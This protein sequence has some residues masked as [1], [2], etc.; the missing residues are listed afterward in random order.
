MV[1]QRGD[2]SAGTAVPEQRGADPDANG[3]SDAPGARV[4]RLD[5]TAVAL[6]ASAEMP[7]TV[8]DALCPEIG[9]RLLA[10]QLQYSRWVLRRVE[11]VEFERDRSVS[12]T[13]TVEF[14]IRPDAP[15]FAAADEEF[16]LVPLSIMQR[17]TLVNLD[18]RDENGLA[19]GVPGLRVNQ[20]LDQSVLLAA[21]AAAAPESVLPDAP[22][23][24]LIQT[25]VTGRKDAVDQAF[26]D[27]AVPTPGDGLD[28]LRY[29][30]LFTEVLYRMRHDFTLYVFL[31]VKRRQRMLR[32]SFEEP[33][34]WRYDRARLRKNRDAPLG[35]RGRA[36]ADE[37]A[38][39]P[40]T[41][42]VHRYEPG[43]RARY[44]YGVGSAFGIIPTKI[45]F[46]VPSAERAASY[47]FEVRAPQGLRIVRASLVAGRPNNPRK[48]VSADHW[49]GHSP[50]VG[51]HATEIPYGSLCRAQVE[52]RLPSG[53]WLATLVASCWLITAVL[54][55]VAF[56]WTGRAVAQDWTPDQATNVCVLLISTSA[57]V[58]AAIA[59]REFG[60][61]AA[62]LLTLMRLLGLVAIL[63]PVVVAAFLAYSSNGDPTPTQLLRQEQATWTTLVIAVLI[64]LWVTVVW[65]LS[66]W[67]E[68]AARIADRPRDDGRGAFARLRR[69]IADRIQ[70]S[71]WN[72]TRLSRPGTAVQRAIDENFEAALRAYGY[73]TPAIGI[74]SAEGSNEWYATTDDSHRADVEAIDP[75]SGGGV[76]VRCGDVE[77]ACVH[78][79]ACPAV[80][81][82]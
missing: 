5:P 78:S 58:A 43:L 54:G 80:A 28:A 30:G 10:A 32:M 72:M 48:H 46:Q 65:A 1:R 68:W 14:L 76:R 44:R 53:G 24:K 21:A 51:L 47:H 6:Q 22:G 8:P 82:A 15:R 34:P 45:R 73:R 20:Q 55:S 3:R 70:D 16:W 71:P 31:P 2:D 57:G 62:R 59:Q 42:N 36:T 37:Q 23:R 69:W 63:M 17:R 7:G 66:L 9:R 77:T 79:G 25:V 75:G 41:A 74:R 18:L 26:R 38:A 61:L 39:D 50:T 27:F 81:P 64:A 49:E 60:G 35:L 56:H 12:R 67:D 40:E 13:V 52:L 29:N 11:K 33:T 19:V 4:W